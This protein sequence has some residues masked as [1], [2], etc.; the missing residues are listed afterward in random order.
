[1]RFP[2]PPGLGPADSAGQAHCIGPSPLETAPAKTRDVIAVIEGC[3]SIWPVGPIRRDNKI[4]APD[5]NE[6][7]VFEV[8]PADLSHPDALTNCL[9]R[10]ALAHNIDV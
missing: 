8:S 2:G 4:Y 6:V 5:D 1:M 3:N 7:E 10:E 9:I